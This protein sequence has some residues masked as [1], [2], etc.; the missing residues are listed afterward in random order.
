MQLEASWADWVQE[1]A[2]LQ[3][4]FSGRFCNDRDAEVNRRWHDNMRVDA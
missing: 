4:G 2:G 3:A 1:L